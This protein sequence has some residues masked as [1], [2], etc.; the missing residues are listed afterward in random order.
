MQTVLEIDRGGLKQNIALTNPICRIGSGSGMELRIEGLDSHAVTL[1][2]QNG[3]TFVYNRCSRLI[4]LGSK[5]IPADKTMEWPIGL[6]LELSKTTKIRLTNGQPTQGKV[7]LAKSN[8]GSVPQST[9]S[10]D[11]GNRRNQRSIFVGGFLLL[12]GLLLF[13][14]GALTHEAEMEEDFKSLVACLSELESKPQSGAYREIRHLLQNA[15]LRDDFRDEAIRE[16]SAVLLLVESSSNPIPT[17]IREEIDRF[18]TLHLRSN[19]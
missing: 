17:E 6:T 5:S 4:T 11:Q 13:S 16:V 15:I 1:R 19:R 9:S 3:R 18:I 10:G 12:F 14:T 7:P 8:T 2:V